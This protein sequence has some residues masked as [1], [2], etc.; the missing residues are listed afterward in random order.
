MI[1]VIW[2]TTRIGSVKSVPPPWNAPLAPAR[3]T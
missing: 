1:F 3:W 2:F